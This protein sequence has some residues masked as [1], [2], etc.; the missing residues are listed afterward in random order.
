MLVALRVTLRMVSP[1]TIR[2]PDFFLVSFSDAPFAS[3]VHS[4]SP[5]ILPSAFPA[6]T[7]LSWLTARTVPPFHACFMAWRRGRWYRRQGRRYTCQCCRCHRPSSWRRCH[8]CGQWVGKG[9]RPERCWVMCTRSCRGCLM[10]LLQQPLPRE[11][12]AL[13]AEYLD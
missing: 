9:C 11:L 8:L 12:G 4:P 6:R 5:L 13:V 3:W 1:A 10:L 7:F 2:D